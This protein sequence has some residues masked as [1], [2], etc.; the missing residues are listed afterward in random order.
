MWE[1]LWQKYVPGAVGN[2]EVIEGVTLGR[3]LVSSD[4]S[5]SQRPCHG[6]EGRA[7]HS[8]DQRRPD[9]HCLIETECKPYV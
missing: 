6:R 4:W 7:W 2:R 1:V 9:Q 5:E 3:L 8:C